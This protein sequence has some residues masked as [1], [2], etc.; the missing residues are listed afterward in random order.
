MHLYR[1]IIFLLTAMTSIALQAQTITQLYGNFLK[2]HGAE[3]VQLSNLILK[4]AY[5]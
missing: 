1:I 2:K 4:K 3:K 5:Q